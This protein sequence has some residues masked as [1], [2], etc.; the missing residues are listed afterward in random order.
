MELTQL[1]TFLKVAELLS[2]SKAAQALDYS[3]SAVT[4][5]IKQLENELQVPLFER[6]GKKVN[7]TEEG[8]TLK[9]YGTTILAT[10]HEATCVLSRTATPNGT[11]R[12]GASESL[13]AY[14]LPSILA[15]YHKIYPNVALSL[16]TGTT[17]ELLDLMAQ[18]QVDFICLF[19][20]K[21]LTNE[22]QLFFTQDEPFV[23][24]VSTTHPL[25][26]LTSIPLKALEYENFLLT[27]AGCTYR[28]ILQYLFLENNLSLHPILE[29]G[30]TEVIKRCCIQ[31]LGIALLP[32]FTVSDECQKNELS[33][34]DISP[35]NIHLYH[36]IICHKQ[37]YISST[38]QEFITLYIH[39]LSRPSIH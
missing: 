21:T 26:K 24:V 14:V 36:Q 28:Q 18:N 8:E 22:H 2:F 6:I 11:L 32:Y 12:I 17:S 33:I 3:Q 5:Q 38:I 34:L 13:C 27:E 10:V 29:I 25:S 15:E 19:A 35:L 4:I 30:N 39:T 31:G 37:K 7:L 16:K 20:E 23:F 9:K 1:N